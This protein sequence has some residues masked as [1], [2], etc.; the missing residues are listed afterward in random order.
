MARSKWKGPFV[1]KS[2]FKSEKESLKSWSRSTMIVPSFVGLSLNVYNGQ[3]FIQIKIT[4]LMIGH[5]LGE[6]AHT[7]KTYYHKKQK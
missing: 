4:N 6:F 2:F 1:H 3:R 5:K 7:R